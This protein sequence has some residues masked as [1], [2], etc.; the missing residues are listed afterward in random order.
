MAAGA[1]ERRLEWAP[2][3]LDAYLATLVRITEEDP[4]AARQLAE[5]VAQSVATIQSYPSVGTPAT[6]RGERRYPIANT[7][8][9]INYRVTRRAI[10]I[11]LWY[12]ARQHVVR[13]P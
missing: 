4:G 3:A 7:G 12:R 2:R 5:R 1:L 10:R 13:Q 6:R 9:V 8:H 11:Q